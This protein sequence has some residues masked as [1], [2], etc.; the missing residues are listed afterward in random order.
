LNILVYLLRTSVVIVHNPCF[1]HVYKNVQFLS[2]NAQ[3]ALKRFCVR[4]TVCILYGLRS[5]VDTQL[6]PEN[7]TV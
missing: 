5:I 7:M 1:E 6:K 4:F 2:N 3:Y